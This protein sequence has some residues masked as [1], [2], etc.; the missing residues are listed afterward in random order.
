MGD[1]VGAVYPV[2][3]HYVSP[4]RNVNFKYSYWPS[5]DLRDGKKKMII[6]DYQGQTYW[7]S[8]SF[9]DWLPESMRSWWPSFLGIAA[10]YGVRNFDGMGYRETQF[11]VALDY[12]LTKLPGDS[13]ILKTL[14]KTGNYF[15]FPAPALR[16]TPTATFFVLY[17]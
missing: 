11:Y 15:H 3:Q 10:G 8:V 6:D 12:D 1:V 16:I 4:L 7:L 2:L 17:F 9:Y 5:Q 14:K 13:W